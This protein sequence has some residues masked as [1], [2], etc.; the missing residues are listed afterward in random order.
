MVRNATEH[1]QTGSLSNFF[2]SE[3]IAPTYFLITDYV[4]KSCPSFWTH[5]TVTRQNTD[6][7]VKRKAE[8]IK[9]SETVHRWTEHASCIFVEIPINEKER[10]KYFINGCKAH[11]WL[12][13]TQLTTNSPPKHIFR[14][15]KTTCCWHQTCIAYVC[16]SL[17]VISITI[18]A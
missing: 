8:T 11:T 12:L 9:L 5:Q 7:E 3:R 18:S 10:T 6:I 13:N 4:L 2:S 1:K 16:L 17:T 14:K 15:S